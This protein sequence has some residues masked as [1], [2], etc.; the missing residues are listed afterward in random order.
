LPDGPFKLATREIASNLGE[1]VRDELRKAKSHARAHAM[2]KERT[3]RMSP[4]RMHE[5]KVKTEFA[6]SKNTP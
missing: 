3:D 4:A 6:K 2:L 1:G 5:S